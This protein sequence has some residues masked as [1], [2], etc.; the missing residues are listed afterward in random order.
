[1]LETVRRL[2][3]AETAFFEV[4]VLNDPHAIGVAGVLLKAVRTVID[5]E[6]D[7]QSLI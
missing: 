3:L 7:L 4:L 2:P 6:V 1:M 5:H